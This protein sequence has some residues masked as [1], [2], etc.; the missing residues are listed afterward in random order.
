MI[1]LVLALAVG[2]LIPLAAPAIVLLDDNWADAGRTIQNP[3]IEAA[4]FASTGSSL[5]TATNSMTLSLS[6]SAVMVVSYFT[7]NTDTPTQLA[8]GDSLKATFRLL[9]G[10]VAAANS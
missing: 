2:A 4:W 6:S 8:V 3:P 7:T 1:R 9:F 5:T 10:S